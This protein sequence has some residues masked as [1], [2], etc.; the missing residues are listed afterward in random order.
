MHEKNT[1]VKNIIYYIFLL[2]FIKKTFCY[3]TQEIDE[4][5]RY[6]LYFIT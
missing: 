2:N 3:M 5:N 4:I 1:V 6:I